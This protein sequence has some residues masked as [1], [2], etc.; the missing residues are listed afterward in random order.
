MNVH[1]TLGATYIYTL[2]A[3]NSRHYYYQTP[4]HQN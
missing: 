2:D 1:G 4:L 3:M